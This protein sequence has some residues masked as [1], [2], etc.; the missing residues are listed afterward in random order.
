MNLQLYPDTKNNLINS[1]LKIYVFTNVFSMV[2]N[3]NYKIF[4]IA[5]KEFT[6]TAE[7]AFIQNY[8]EKYLKALLIYFICKQSKIL[9]LLLRCRE[10]F[11]INS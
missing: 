5:I 7:L 3:K 1:F 9:E 4:A 2:D 10:S 8:T 6:A 11:V